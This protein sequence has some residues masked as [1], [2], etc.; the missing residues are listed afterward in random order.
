MACDAVNNVIYVSDLGNLRLVRLDL[1]SKATAVVADNLPTL[2]L[3]LDA[4]GALYATVN[5]RAINT[6]FKWANPLTASNATV[7]LTFTRQ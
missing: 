4:A 2:G 6:I 5:D 1:A 7:P 3:A